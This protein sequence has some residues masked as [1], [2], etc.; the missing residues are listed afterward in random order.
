MTFK[1]AFA[2]LFLPLSFAHATD[3]A[4]TTRF[5]GLEL[6]GVSAGWVSNT[7]GG[8]AVGEVVTEKMGGDWLQKKHIGNVKYE[9]ISFQA[10]TSASRGFYEWIKSSFSQKYSRKNGAIVSADYNYDRTPGTTTEFF[11]AIITEMSMPALDAA[12]KDAAK[13]TIKFKPEYTR[14][15]IGGAQIANNGARSDA[16]GW[17][18]SDFRLRIDGLEE[19]AARVNKIEA[20]TIKQ[21]VAENAVGEQRDY[22]QEPTS[23]EIPNLVITLP[24]SHAKPFYDWHEDFVIKGNNSADKEKTGTLEYLSPNRKTVLFTVYFKGLGIYKVSPDKSEASAEDIRRVKA[25]MYCE[26]IRFSYNPGAL[27]A[28]RKVKARSRGIASEKKRTK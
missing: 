12:S 9:E 4:Y 1:A 8:T 16:T 28:R 21:K 6:D 10:G 15:K 11:N 13:M 24:E 25:E 7:E 23:V 5:Y 18:V 19:P 22:E 20:L 17:R 26:D 3:R 14:K 27:E 2:L